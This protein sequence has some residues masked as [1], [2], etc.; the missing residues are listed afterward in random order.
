FEPFADAHLELALRARRRLERRGAAADPRKFGL[1]AL[2]RIAKF[3]FV[4]APEHVAAPEE[5]PEG[6]GLLAYDAKKDELRIAKPANPSSKGEPERV[7]AEVARCNTQDLMHAGGVT[8]RRG[9]PR[10]AKPVPSEVDADDDADAEP[11]HRGDD[12]E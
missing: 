3:R 12:A 8:W 10:F 5:V 6:W 9:Q 4:A 2:G 7:L 11:Q 1:D